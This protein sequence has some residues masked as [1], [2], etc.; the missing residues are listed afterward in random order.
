ML[1]EK[2]V[3]IC[4]SIQDSRYTWS[5]ACLFFESVENLHQPIEFISNQ[6]TYLY[7]NAQYFSKNWLSQIFLDSFEN[8]HK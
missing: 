1:A 8:E 4:W 6:S 3:Y 7:E 5:L 2:I